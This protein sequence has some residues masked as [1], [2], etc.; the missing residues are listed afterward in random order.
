MPKGTEFKKDYGNTSNHGYSK[1]YMRV[2][3]SLLRN[4]SKSKRA[5]I[6]SCNEGQKYKPT[7]NK[8]IK[9]NRK[10]AK[11][12]RLTKKKKGYMI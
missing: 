11:L 3:C 7:Q 10:K 12:L 6:Q 9:Q 5:S 8:E 1:E 2:Y 4:L